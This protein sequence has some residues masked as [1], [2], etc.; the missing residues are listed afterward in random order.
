[1]LSVNA[2]VSLDNPSQSYFDEVEIRN[3]SDRNHFSYLDND[4]VPCEM[5]IFDD[6]LSFLRKTEDHVLQLN[7]RDEK[8]ALVSSEEGN[9]KI[10]IKVVDF[11]INSDILVMRYLID[12]EE[13]T[14]RIQYY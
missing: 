8:F 13:R 12:D 1:M 11:Q 7:L 6:G 2:K 5:H 14:I 9:I 4:K 3:I 10:D